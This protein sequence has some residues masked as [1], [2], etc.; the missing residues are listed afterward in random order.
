MFDPTVVNVFVETLVVAIVV[1]FNVPSAFL[2][3]GANALTDGKANTVEPIYPNP[4]N[5]W[6]MLDIA[7]PDTV[8]TAI[9]NDWPGMAVVPSAPYLFITLFVLSYHKCQGVP[10]KESVVPDTDVVIA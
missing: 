10:D 1:F 6:S 8:T 3:F 7:P 9:G 5:I 4:L 2:P